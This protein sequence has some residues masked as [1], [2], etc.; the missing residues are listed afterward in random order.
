MKDIKE[1]RQSPR[2]GC[3]VPIESQSGNV[4]SASRTVDIS[5]G[6]LGLVSSRYIP[7]DEEIPV[8]V[9]FSPDEEPVWLV[10]RVKWVVPVAET[11][12]FRVGLNF[13]R[14]I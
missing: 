14:E 9:A 4:F 11:G 1:L 3:A 7:V 10:G 8:E 12:L 5:Q 2:Q 13:I 6:G